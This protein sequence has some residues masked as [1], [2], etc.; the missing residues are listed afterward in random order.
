M[1]YRGIVGKGHGIGQG[2]GY[3]TINIPLTDP[4]L[5]GVFAANVLVEGKEYPAAAFADQHR[6][7]LE[8]H[9]LDFD[10]DLYGKEVVIEI[11]RKVREAMRFPDK[12]DLKRAIHADVQKIR[13]ILIS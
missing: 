1:D 3:P 6:K 10:G 2:L 11:V 7:L 4:E 8:A 5:S 12:D 9:L 13:L